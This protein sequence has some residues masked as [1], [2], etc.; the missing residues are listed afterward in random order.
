MADY[1]IALF[2]KNSASSDEFVVVRQKRPLPIALDDEEPQH[3][4]AD[5][6]LWDIPSTHL[7]PKLNNITSESYLAFDECAPDVENALEK[8]GLRGFDVSSSVQ[9]ILMQ[10]CAAKHMNQ[11]WSY[12]KLVE[13]P[14]FGPGLPTN[15]LFFMTEVKSD[16]FVLAVVFAP[17]GCSNASSDDAN[18]AVYGDALIVDLTGCHFGARDQLAE[19]IT[20][21]PRNL[22][23]FAT[24]HHRDHVDGLSTIQRCNPSAILVAHEA[25]IRRIGKGTIG[26]R[27]LNVCGG[28]TLFIGGQAFRV[29]SAPGH[30]DGHMALLHITTHTL[31]VGDHCV[32]QGSAVLDAT[33]GGNMKDY[34]ET[35]HKFLELSPHSIIPMHGRPNLWPTNLLCGYVKHRKQREAK[36]L[37]AIEG[38]ARTLYEVV[39]KAYTDV[40]HNMWIGAA[41]NV[42]LHVEHLAYQQ[43]LPV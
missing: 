4:V 12:W 31:I 32:G 21:L 34:L 7:S 18:S 2:V 35:T 23:I 39:S 3:C 28:S 33:S 13:E 10:I 22:V 14:D 11:P 1:K 24:H 15:T 36:V 37:K 17:G 25:T 27:C 20:S 26:F 5:S 42:K 9:Q 43:K 41:S 16:E 6:D 8:L 30:T 19:I 38:G 29:I 40:H